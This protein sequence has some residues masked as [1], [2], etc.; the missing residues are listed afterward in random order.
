M[1]TGA[2]VDPYRAHNFIVEIDSVAVAGF[3]EVGGLSTDGDVV[4]YREGAD[5]PL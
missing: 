4:E 1:P 3:S 2:R 5:I